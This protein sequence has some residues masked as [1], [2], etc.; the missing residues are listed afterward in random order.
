MARGE[1]GPASL[2]ENCPLSNPARLGQISRR[3]HLL[4]PWQKNFA[5]LIICKNFQEDRATGCK[6]D[7]YMGER[8]GS[9]K[10]GTYESL[11]LK[12]MDPM[13]SYILL[14]TLYNQFFNL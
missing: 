2:F 1:P 13:T 9:P 7:P 3:E 8:E 11:D 12:V 6:A 10:I 14:P 4:Q 5:T